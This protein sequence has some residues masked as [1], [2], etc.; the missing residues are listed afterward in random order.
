MLQKSEIFYTEKPV[1]VLKPFKAFG[2]QFSTGELFNWRRH[3][4]TK[5]RVAQMFFTRQLS[6]GGV[7]SDE[8]KQYVPAAAL[9]DLGYSAEDVNDK[10]D[11]EQIK[12]INATE[13]KDALNALLESFQTE[14]P[15][16]KSGTKGRK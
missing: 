12:A 7:I 3:S 4:M 9:L 16:V 2:Q 1:Y 10:F 5:R 8:M 6:H 15:K 11:K 13:S 14:K